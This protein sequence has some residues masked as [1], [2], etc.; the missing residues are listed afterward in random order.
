MSFQDVSKKALASSS[1]F[2]HGI[3][4]P[5]T[6]IQLVKLGLMLNSAR[7]IWKLPS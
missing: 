7:G 5:L 3:Y 2:I 6:V 1:S 4:S